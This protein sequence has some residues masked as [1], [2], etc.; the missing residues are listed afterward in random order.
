MILEV[1]WDGL[2]TLSFGLSQCHGH[3]SWLVCEVALTNVMAQSRSTNPL[4]FHTLAYWLIP[5]TTQTK[6]HLHLNPKEYGFV[7]TCCTKSAIQ[8]FPYLNV[9]NAVRCPSRSHFPSLSHMC[10]QFNDVPKW[11]RH[12]SLNDKPVKWVKFSDNGLIF[13][14]VLCTGVIFSFLFVPKSLVFSS[15]KEGP[16]IIIII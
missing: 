16:N 8:T 10:G 5:L 15:V 6:T 9:T 3:G 14:P 7:S 12:K 2:W 11:R 1:C 13:M 4:Q